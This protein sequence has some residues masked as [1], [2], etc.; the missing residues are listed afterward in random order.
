MSAAQLIVTAT[1][2]A[3][4]AGLGWF[5]FRRRA[6]TSAT[7]TGGVQEV[8]VVVKGGYRPD[9]IRAR[10]GAPLRIVFDRQE[11]GDCS[12]RVVF[13]DLFRQ[14]VP[15]AVHGNHRR[16]GATTDGPVRVCLRHEHAPR[17]LGRRGRRRRCRRRS[18]RR[19]AG[20]VIVTPLAMAGERRRCRPRVMLI[21]LLDVQT[22]RQKTR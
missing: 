11:D 1:G 6:A 13:P 12:S 2:A 10:T 20:R 18:T 16:A 7:E 8:R 15:P 14:Q 5:F 4:I 17:R 22:V 9:A 21:L 19:C 3:L